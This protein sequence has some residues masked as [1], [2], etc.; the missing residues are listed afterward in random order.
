MIDREK[1]IK[2]LT[3]CRH[4][5]ISQENCKECPYIYDKRSKHS[6]CEGVLHYDALAL[7]KEQEEKIY[8]AREIAMEESTNATWREDYEA[9]K[10]LDRIAQMLS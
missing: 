10:V 2:G 5:A 3:I 9:W 6:N 7:L 1:V 8:S 4:K